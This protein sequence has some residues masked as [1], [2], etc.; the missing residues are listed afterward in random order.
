[1]GVVF[2]KRNS[3]EFCLLGVSGMSI[4]KLVMNGMNIFSVAI[5]GEMGLKIE[6]DPR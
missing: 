5:F 1:M 4:Y 3:L 6:S 2:L